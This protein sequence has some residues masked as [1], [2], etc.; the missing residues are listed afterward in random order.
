[1]SNQILADKIKLILTKIDDKFGYEDRSQKGEI[2]Y[3]TFSKSGKTRIIS[4]KL[5]DKGNVVSEREAHNDTVKIKS[6]RLEAA[7]I[8]MKAAYIEK[9]FDASVDGWLKII[10]PEHKS[11]EELDN[12]AFAAVKAQVY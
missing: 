10:D 6:F 4:A 2:R 1:M 5:D 11:E 3:Y 7:Y 8:G 9:M 12:E